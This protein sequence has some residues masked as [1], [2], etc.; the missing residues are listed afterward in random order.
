MTL[1]ERI[2]QCRKQ[3]GITQE[4]LGERLGVSRQAVSKWESEQ[5]TPDLQYL[6][7]MCA[8]F[9]V[10][11]D[12]LLFGEGGEGAADRTPAAATPETETCPNCGQSIMQGA[13]FCPKCGQSMAPLDRSGCFTLVLNEK[14]VG[15]SAAFDA[16]LELMRKPYIRPAIT[17]GEVAELIGTAPVVLCRGLDGKQVRE[18]KDI[19]WMCG[20][21]LEVYQDGQAHKSLE[22]LKQDGA[23]PLASSAFEKKSEGLGF[24]GVV[25]A[26]VV[27]LIIVSFL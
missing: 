17:S 14:A 25:G 4:E 6:K 2:M 27:A 9:Q 10:T 7:S 15:N 18:A 19:F 23:V 1:G 21:V 16:A 24:W 20:D 26:V 8:L 3:A 5:T 12:W 13:A 11:A 22:E